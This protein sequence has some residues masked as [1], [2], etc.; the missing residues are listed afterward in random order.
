MCLCVFVS[1]TYMLL[2]MPKSIGCS[3]DTSNVE[4]RARW[5]LQLLFSSAFVVWWYA[6]YMGSNRH[7]T[8][9]HIESIVFFPLNFP[10]CALLFS[11]YISNSVRSLLRNILW[12]EPWMHKVAYVVYDILIKLW[13][14]FVWHIAIN[15]L[16]G[17]ETT[18]AYTNYAHSLAMFG[19][20]R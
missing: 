5:R 6:Y 17:R 15:S 20:N 14:V 10:L 12:G 18:H 3:C 19:E 16:G 1:H 2:C 7:T 9:N 4:R 13:I 11:R 8:P